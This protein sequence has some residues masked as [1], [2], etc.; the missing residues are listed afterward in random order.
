MKQ[1][2]PP[3]C[4]SNIVLIGK[5]DRGRWVAR[6]QNGLFGG[7]FVSRAAAVKFALFENGNRPDAIFDAAHILELHSN[8]ATLAPDLAAPHDR[9]PI[10]RRAA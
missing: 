8:S 10:E 2:E 6:E 5:N 3:S 7:L 1:T 4:S 9:I